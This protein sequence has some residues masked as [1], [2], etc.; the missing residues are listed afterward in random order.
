MNMRLI[1]AG[2]EKIGSASRAATAL[3][4]MS[5]EQFRHLGLNQVAYVRVRL[6]DGDLFFLI[7]GADGVP[8]ATVEDLEGAVEIAAEQGLDFVTVH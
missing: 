1:G 2:G 7:H 6:R 3:R 4:G 8:V 5:S